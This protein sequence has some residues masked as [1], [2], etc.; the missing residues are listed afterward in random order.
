[1]VILKGIT[2]NIAV[3]TGIYAICG[4]CRRSHYRCWRVTVELPEDDD[5]PVDEEPPDAELPVG[6][7]AVAVAVPGTTVIE[8]LAPHPPKHKLTII[9]GMKTSANLPCCLNTGCFPFASTY[10][11]KSRYMVVCG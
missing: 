4:A 2:P 7:D 6:L 9:K 3:K 11:Q 1:M 8:A 5:P 10:P